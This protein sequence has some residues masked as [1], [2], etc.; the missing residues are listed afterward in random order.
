MK[1]Q[2]YLMLCIFLSLAICQVGFAAGGKGNVKQHGE[3]LYVW[4]FDE[5]KGNKTEDETAGLVGEF[6]G[7]IKWAEGI[8]G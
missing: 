8:S 5:G 7:D 3:T 2:V 1:A 6:T 4:H